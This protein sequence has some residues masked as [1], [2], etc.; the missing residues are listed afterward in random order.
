MILLLLATA[1]AQEYRFPTSTEDATHFYPTAYFDHGNVDWACGTTTYGGHRGSDFGVGSFT[2]MDAGRDVVAAAPGWV[3]QTHDGEFDRC[4]SG[5]CSGGG[6]YGNHVRVVHPDGRTTIYAHLKKDSVE[7]VADSHVAC[8]QRLGLVGSSG[9]STGPHLH[10]EV[11][12]ANDTRF[13]PFVGDCSDTPTTAWV[14]QGIHEDL[15]GLSCDTV[16]PCAPAHSIACGETLQM[17]NDGDGSTQAHAAY[18]CTDFQYS[19]PE[20]GFWFAT[21]LEED[22]QV[23]LSGLSADLDLFALDNELCDTSNCLAVSHSS[24]TSDE[25]LVFH[26]TPNQLF[27]LVVDGWENA[28]SDFTLTVTCE[29]S[30]P[31]DDTNAP[32]TSAF[33]SGTVDTQEETGKGEPVLGCGC[34]HTPN[35]A[36]LWTLIPLV[37]VFTQKRRTADSGLATPISRC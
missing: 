16:E 25:S 21:D 7:V 18:G 13:D 33:D 8:G 9:Y 22:V 34:G 30:W 24:D 4:T 36:A 31:E 1:H 23:S 35:P 6:G 19:G 17:R 10:F 20:Q 5:E 12:D 26:A 29:G 2:G 14:D 11:R 28:S 3:T 32:D 27:V 15:P 37:V